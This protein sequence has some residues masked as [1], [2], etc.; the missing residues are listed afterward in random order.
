LYSAVKGGHA[1]LW[2]LTAVWNSCVAKLYRRSWSS[3]DWRYT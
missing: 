1:A 3:A 2:S